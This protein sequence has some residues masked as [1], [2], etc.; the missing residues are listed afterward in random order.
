[1]CF[2]WFLGLVEP[3]RCITD[4]Y[5]CVRAAAM[6]CLANMDRSGGSHHVTGQFR[7]VQRCF[8]LVLVVFPP[9]FGGEEP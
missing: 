4:E 5:G 6:R 7:V 9:W 2:I 8:P 1:M 3:S